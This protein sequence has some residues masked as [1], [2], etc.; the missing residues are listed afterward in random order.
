MEFWDCND[1]IWSL[2]KVEKALREATEK[3]RVTLLEIVLKKFKPYGI[4]AVALISES[5]F[6]VHTWPEE[7]YIALDIYTCG[8]KAVPEAAV[9][10]FKRCFQPRRMKILELERGKWP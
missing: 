8:K 9:E 6:A 7:R 2:E 4:S 3:A 5:H 1:N 10:V